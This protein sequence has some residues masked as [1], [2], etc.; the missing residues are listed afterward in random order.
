MNR[1]L[2]GGLL[3]AAT[4]PASAQ[5]PGKKSGKELVSCVKAALSDNKSTIDKGNYDPFTNALDDCHK[6]KSLLTP[7]L[8]ELIWVALIDSYISRVG[9]NGA[10]SN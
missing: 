8:P 5:D 4:Q 9:G 6:A 10:G 7:S 2:A 3:L 1:L